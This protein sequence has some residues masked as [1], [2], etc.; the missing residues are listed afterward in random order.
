MGNNIIS[1]I[2]EELKEN[3]DLEYKKGACNFFKE[4]INPMGVRTPTVR[5]ISAKY[6]SEV[7]DL[8]KKNIFV[9]CEKLLTG[10]DEEKT[11][12]FDW[13]YRIRKQYTKNDFKVFEGWLKKYVS[14]WGACDTFCT[15][16]FGYFI[17]QFTEYLVELK[18]WAKSKNRW[19]RRASAVIL[20]YPNRERKYLDEAFEI[21]DILFNDEDDLVQK[22]YGWMLKEI[23]N[24]YPKKVFEYVMAR[25][26]NMPRTALRYAIEKLP[27]NYKVEAMVK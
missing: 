13:A 21:A 12:A 16:A 27:K 7:K 2:Q 23:S 8:G 9:L 6:F 18:K 25:K 26:E 20:I 17:F 1:K 14:N 24:L 10:Y 15:H 22:G 3:I 4:K 19:L 5:K 11:V